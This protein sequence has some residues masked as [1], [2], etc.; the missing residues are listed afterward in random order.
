MRG[1]LFV[2]RAMSLG[3]VMAPAAWGQSEPAPPERSEKKAPPKLTDVQQKVATITVD[4]AA[5]KGALVERPALALLGKDAV[6]LVDSNSEVDGKSEITSRFDGQNYFFSSIENKTKFE[7]SPGR[8]V[9][10]LAGYSVV[11][12][13]NSAK[14]VPGTLAWRSALNDRLFLFAN[15]EEKKAF[16]S[17]SDAFENVD[18]GLQGFSPVVLVEEEV[19]RRGD[20]KVEVIFEGRRFR[21]AS[22]SDRDVFAA[23]P[24]R[25]FPVLGGLD[26]ALL[27]QGK[28]GL[29]AA[30][31]SVVYKN[32][33]YSFAT[34]ETRDQFVAQAEA[35]S[36][37]DIARGGVDQVARV[38]GK[39]EPVGHYGISAIH[40][41]LRYLFVDEFNRE[42]FQ[43]DPENY[44]SAASGS[45]PP[46]NSTPPAPPASAP[47]GKAAPAP[48]AT[49]DPNVEEPEPVK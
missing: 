14:L 15:E 36:D 39:G 34:P 11:A 17:S 44:L 26:V 1:C 31:N 49:A 29:G 33:L 45:A 6:A 2:A 13:K 25:Y 12:W 28:L 32:R 4:G 9:P 5:V 40:R 48:S 23:N 37:F 21:F 35:L 41:G 10:A 22:A 42:R 24:G 46:V 19:L 8:Y 43:Q 27:A 16:D 38:D 18:L 7:Q 3:L 20:K 30:K 47:T